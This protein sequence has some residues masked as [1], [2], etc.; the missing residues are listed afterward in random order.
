MQGIDMSRRTLIR[1]LIHPYI[2][3]K[4]KL[5]VTDNIYNVKHINVLFSSIN[6]TL[7]LCDTTQLNL[8][9]QCVLKYAETIHKQTH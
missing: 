6:Y 1:F 8:T 2:L 3:Y 5:V 9:E 4:Y 7:L